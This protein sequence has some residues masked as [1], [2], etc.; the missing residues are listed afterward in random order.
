MSA[1]RSEPIRRSAWRVRRGDAPW[2][3]ATQ[4]LL[5]LTG[6]LLAAVTF[7]GVLSMPDLAYHPARDLELRATYDTYVETGVPLLKHNGT[8]SWYG[9]VPGDG[10]TRAAGDDDPGSY[11]VASWMSHLTGSDSPYPGLRWAMAL[12]CALPLLI[13]P[14]TIARVFRRARAGY[15]MLLL[16]PVTWLVNKGTVLIGTEYGLSDQV[17]PLRVYALYGMAA[18]MLFLSLV[19]L[20]YAATHRLGVRALVAVSLLFVVLASVSNLMRSLSGVGVAVAVGVLWWLSW[21]RRLRLL[22]AVGASL[23]AVAGALVLPGLFMDRIDA[24]RQPLLSAEASSLPAAH[25][26]WHPLYLGLSYP[27]P[28]TGEA[29]PFGIPWSD[30]FGWEKAREVDPDVLVASAEYDAIMKDLYLDQVR[31]KPVAAARL[32]L[33]KGLY[34]MKQ[35]AA[36]IVL[37]VVG[38]LLAW[39]RPGPHRR[40]MAAITAIALPTLLF[41]LVP[42]VL[43][44]PMLYYYSEVVAGLGL[45]SAVALG[46][47]VWAYTTLPAFVRSNERKRLATRDPLEPAPAGTRRLSVVVPSRNGA[48]VLPATLGVL[49][50]ELGAD[51]E[52][53]VVENGS[54]DRTADVLDELA[55]TW[56]H[57]CALVVLSS[58][59]GLGNALRTGVLASS[60][61]RLLLTA[62]DLPFG[63]SDLEAFWALPPEAV[64][65]IGSKA[66]PDSRV[67]RSRLRTVQSRVFRWLRSATLHSSVG[68]SQG[69]I[70]VDG[71]WARAFAGVSRET[72]LMWTVELVL[73]AEQQGLD[74]YEVAVELV[75]TH[76]ASTSRFRFRDAWIGVRE[77]WQLALRKDDYSAE[78]Y[79]TA[80]TV[81][82]GRGG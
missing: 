13:L 53:L 24:E 70:W 62:D 30:E 69:T 60:G 19:L 57:P 2:P 10:L 50:A 3:R 79:P 74:V 31:E 58:R 16:P 6:G 4:V 15:A 72:G 55:R 25:G 81:L 49:G 8:G 18:S 51:D 61:R 41:S 33:A 32:Y 40:M 76:D 11:L 68:D 63:L 46:G 52:I 22:V 59:P 47:L 67:A 80:G 82:A 45:L 17:A 1:A 73:A 29:S 21:S 48:G 35:F 28:I 14:L 38:Y 66:H 9:A 36:M 23:V 12:L 5:L 71:V 75:P 56:E 7:V 39:R 20:A 37:I 42:T 77:I 34:V 65:A 44:M 78:E 43:V 27:Q 64:V 54:T 26:T